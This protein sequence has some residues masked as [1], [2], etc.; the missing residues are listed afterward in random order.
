M[1]RLLCMMLTRFQSLGFS[2]SYFIG[3]GVNTVLPPENY[4]ELC[5]VFVIFVVL[6]AKKR[7]VLTLN[8]SHTDERPGVMGAHGVAGNEAPDA[9]SHVPLDRLSRLPPRWRPCSR[10]NRQL[11][12]SR[13]VMG[14]H[15]LRFSGKGS[16]DV[17]GIRA[18]G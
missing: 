12:S 11:S 13:A 1:F 9:P 15:Q 6:S 5:E 16:R 17:A 8:K 10:T 7:R 4:A 3:Q 14:C 2:V 18:R